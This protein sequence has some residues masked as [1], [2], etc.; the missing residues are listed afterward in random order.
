[1]PLVPVS[2][3]EGLTEVGERRKGARQIMVL[4]VGLIDDGR[5]PTFCLVKNISRAGVQVALFSRLRRESEVRLQVGDEEALSGRIV[6]I[7][8]HVAGIRFHAP[9][10]PECML[11]I[12]QKLTPV[13]RRLSPRVNASARALLRTGGRTYLAELCDISAVGARVRTKKAV[14]LGPTVMLNL[15][16]LP[17]IKTYARWAAGQDLGLVFDSP[18]PISIIAGWLNERVTVSSTIA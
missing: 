2:A 9:L 13:K 3:S 12:T 18:L 17:T 10:E 5:R 16:D 8:K 7:R 15:P 6:W 14:N 1:M 4:R 11:R